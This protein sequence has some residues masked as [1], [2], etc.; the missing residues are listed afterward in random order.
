MNTQTLEQ[1]KLLRFHGMHNAFSEAL[2]NLAINSDRLPNT[3]R[4]G[5]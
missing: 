5:R 4:M 2:Q 3:V 1:M